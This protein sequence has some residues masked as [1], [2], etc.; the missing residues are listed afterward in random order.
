MEYN[1]VKLSGFSLKKLKKRW[2]SFP[3][4]VNHPH[5]NDTSGGKLAKAFRVLICMECHKYNDNG[6]ELY[7]YDSVHCQSCGQMLCFKHLFEMDPSVFKNNRENIPKMC[8]KLQANKFTW[9]CFGCRDDR[10]KTELVCIHI[11]YISI[12]IVNIYIYIYIY[13][14]I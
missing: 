10:I 5:I 7:L 6:Q 13:I 14:Y 12:F 8:Q 3:E 4:H 9:I 2:N 11:Q 1:P